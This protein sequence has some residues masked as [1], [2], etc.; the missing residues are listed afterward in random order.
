MT[1]MNVNLPAT[2]R[3]DFL[4]PA[5]LQAAIGAAVGDLAPAVAVAVVGVEADVEALA[6]LAGRAD[7]VPTQGV[8]LAGKPRRALTTSVSA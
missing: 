3:L 4:R 2:C 1:L 6:V 5:N 8:N 7:R